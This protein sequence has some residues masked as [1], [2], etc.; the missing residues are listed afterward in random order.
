MNP[1]QAPITGTEPDAGPSSPYLA[2]VQFYRAFNG[3]DMSLMAANWASSE[4]VAMDNPSVASN[5]AGTP[6]VLSTSASSRVRHRSTSSSGT[7]PSMSHPHCSTRWAASAA[8]FASRAL[9]CPWPFARPASSPNST[10][11]GVRCITMALSR[12]LGFSASTRPPSSARRVL[13]NPGMQRTR[14]ARR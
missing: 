6:S 10:A 11:C 12:T 7:T 1:I 4:D 13:P 9:I 2:L 8:I 14:C 5:A 3:R